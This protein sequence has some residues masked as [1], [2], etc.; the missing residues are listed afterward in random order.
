MPQRIKKA[1]IPVAGLGTRSLPFSKCIPKEMLPVLETP[2]IQFIVEEC[3][4]AGIEQ[5]ILVTSKAK[6]A[7]EDH[8]DLNVSLDSWLK[9]RGKT[10]LA[11]KMER[12]GRL[13]EVISVRQKEPLGLGHAILCARPILGNEPFVVCLG[14]E[15]FP[16]WTQRPPILT[17]L[18]EAF[19]T[20]KASLVGVVQVERSE[21][22][23]YGI[24]NIGQATLSDRPV[25]I[26]S[27]IE[28]PAPEKAPSHWAIIGRYVFAP[29]ILDE[30]AR[31]KAGTGGEIQL[32]DGMDKLA[33][34]GA[35]FALKAE[36]SR[37]DMGNPFYFV[38]AQIDAA[39]RRP[40]IAPQIQA[41]LESL[42][43]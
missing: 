17:Q 16:P 9:T 41:Y 15:I 39:L 35:L 12:L 40:E 25:K 27:T 23:S 30:L 31:V 19:E 28:K 14:D 43:R 5:V 24:I 8:F 1:V 2:A 42:C 13:C 4:A 26:L 21:S 38:K 37:Y 22:R 3:T 29:E 33:A 32:T 20:Q 18:V 36:G 34:K 6:T 7:I 10:A 11:E